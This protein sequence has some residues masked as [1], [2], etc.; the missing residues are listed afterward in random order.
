MDQIVEINLDAYGD[1]KYSGKVSALQ[2]FANADSDFVVDIEFTENGGFMP[3][4]GMT[5]DAKIIVESTQN[6]VKS[7]F[8][9][10][11]FYDDEDKP[12]VWTVKNG[13]LAKLPIEV[14]LEGDIYT[15]VKSQIDIPV[16]VGLNQDVELFEGFKATVIP[17]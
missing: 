6:P 13:Y 17:N 14:G 7:L 2:M 15:E 10:E 12:F 11:I 16:V 9:D 3:T 1:K 8:Y 5:G 4:L